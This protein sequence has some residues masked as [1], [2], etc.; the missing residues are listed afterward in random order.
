[1]SCERE[2]GR[3]KRS[4]SE[5]GG[6]VERR[7]ERGTYLVSQVL[8]NVAGRG[9]RQ[10]E[11]SQPTVRP[12]GSGLV[13]RGNS[14]LVEHDDG[15]R[16]QFSRVNSGSSGHSKALHDERMRGKASFSERTAS[17][18]A[19]SPKQQEKGRMRS[20]KRYIAHAVHHHPLVLRGVL[21][22]TSKMR[23]DDVVSVQEGKLS[24]GLDPDLDRRTRDGKRTVS[25]RCSRRFQSPSANHRT[26]K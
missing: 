1:M 24:V 15:C 18:E 2:E 8:S 4:A 16:V 21:R 20:H 23:L 25:F 9:R 17:H 19:S 22:Y 11:I 10:Q 13:P 5:E 7:R 6:R 12:A 14:R 3:T 26:H